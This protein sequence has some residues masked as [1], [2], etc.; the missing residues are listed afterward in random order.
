MKA[1]R[2]TSPVGDPVTGW[3]KQNNKSKPG[4]PVVLYGH[5]TTKAVKGWLQ[6][7]SE[8]GAAAG[9]AGR[10]WPC[11]VEGYCGDGLIG[12]GCCARPVASSMAAVL[13]SNP[14]S[15]CDDVL[16]DPTCAGASGLLSSL[17]GV[18]GTCC[19]HRGGCNTSILAYGCVHLMCTRGGPWR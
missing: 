4:P 18:E 15:R 9:A 10:C 6:R 14:C 19:C 2:V 12:D 11:W 13:L 7:C 16:F 1:T 8:A 17:Y 5:T 3:A